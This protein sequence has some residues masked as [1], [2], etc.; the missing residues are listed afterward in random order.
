M[1]AYSRPL[2]ADGTRSN[3]TDQVDG[4][5]EEIGRFG[6]A[7]EAVDERYTSVEAENMLRSARVTGRTRR[8]RKEAIDSA[9]AVLIAERWLGK[10][11]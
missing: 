11:G 6:L 7:V 8:Y 9:A 5:I 2:H 3:T 10:I 1:A 4:F